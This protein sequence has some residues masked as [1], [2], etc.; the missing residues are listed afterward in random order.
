MTVHEVGPNPAHQHL[1]EML[2]LLRTD[3]REFRE[4]MRG[5]LS[6][7]VTHTELAAFHQ[8]F[9]TKLENLV[10]QTGQREEHLKGRIDSLNQKV[11][12]LE[13]KLIQEQEKSGA[14]QRHFLWTAVGGAGALI[15]TNVFQGL[16]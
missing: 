14:L 10:I 3:L 8:L 2:E 4:E 13:G 12:E 11:K 16:M 9:N 1:A 15:G 5:S 6:D 7:R